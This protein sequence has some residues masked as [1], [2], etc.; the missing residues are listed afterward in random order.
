MKKAFAA[1]ILVLTGDLYTA[2][3]RYVLFSM[4]LCP[5]WR[6]G[7]ALFICQRHLPVTPRIRNTGDG[8]LCMVYYT[9]FLLNVKRRAQDI[10]VIIAALSQNIVFFR[11]IANS[12][13]GCQS[14]NSRVE[15]GVL[16][17]LLN[18]ILN[19][20]LHT[21]NLKPVHQAE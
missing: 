14:H 21:I 20:V 8:S 1:A 18:I 13:T 5:S 9:T 10:V 3:R 7:T 4:E 16:V 15:S 11:K 2:V 17:V 12:H 19:Q 6:L